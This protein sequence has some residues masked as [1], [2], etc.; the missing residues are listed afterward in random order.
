MGLKI[1][2]SKKY[3]S[4]FYLAPDYIIICG[5]KEIYTPNS[6]RHF[7]KEKAQLFYIYGKYFQSDFKIFVNIKDM[8]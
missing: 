8:L 4:G 7:F 6:K 1:V 5:L 2:K 3:N